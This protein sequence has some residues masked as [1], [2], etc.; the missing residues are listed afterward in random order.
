[1]RTVRPRRSGFLDLRQIA[2]G[3][4]VVLASSLMTVISLFLPW[5]VRT[6]GVGPHT[7]SAFAYS[8]VAAVVVIVFFLATLFLVIYPAITRDLG[9]PVLPFSTPLIF[10]SLGFILLLVF[11][12]ELGQ[13]SCLLCTGVATASRGFGV[14]LAF[15]SSL[16]YIVGAI[17]LWGARPS[18]RA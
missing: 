10:L 4:Y 8:E 2:I 17:I 13:Y 18:R 16:A 11:D 7:D 1:M 5:L 12:Y 14:Y 9:F 15:I 3:D 6:D